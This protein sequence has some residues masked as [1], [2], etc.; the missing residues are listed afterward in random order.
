MRGFPALVVACKKISLSS[1]RRCTGVL[2]DA[3]A[4]V[5]LWTAIGKQGVA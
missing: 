4:D 2:V 3:C 1:G 5:R